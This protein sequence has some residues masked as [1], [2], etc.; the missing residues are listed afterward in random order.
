MALKVECKEHTVPKA[1]SW[2]T[3]ERSLNQ[4]MVFVENND[5][6]QMVHAGYVGAK[7]FLP[8]AGFPK[9]LVTQVTT[10]CGKILNR[11]LESVDPPPSIDQV[12]E[13]L[14]QDTTTQEDD[15][16]E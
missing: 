7:A 10:E 5:T 8:L 13:M 16:D 15:S 11:K 4:H 6:K 2:G 9:E 1:T 3:V 12:A 14:S